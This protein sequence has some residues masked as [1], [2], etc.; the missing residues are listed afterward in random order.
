MSWEVVSPCPKNGAMSS[1][2]QA[3]SPV[4]LVSVKPRLEKLDLQNLGCHQG[5]LDLPPAWPFPQ[6]AFISLS[7]LWASLWEMKSHCMC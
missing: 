1:P 5:D 7:P 4:P 6:E 3:M 2:S